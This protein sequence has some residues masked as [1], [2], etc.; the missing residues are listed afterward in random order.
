MEILCSQFTCDITLSDSSW[1]ICK[2]LV[3]QSFFNGVGIAYGVPRDSLSDFD[4][5]VYCLEQN[6]LEIDYDR[7]PDAT[8]SSWILHGCTR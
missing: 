3:G 1:G 4:I 5:E 6:E 8:L 2:A 7:E